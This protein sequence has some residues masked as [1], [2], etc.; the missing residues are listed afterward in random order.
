MTIIRVKGFKIFTDRHGKTRCYY[1]ATG[2]KIDLDKAPIGSAG[3][4]AECAKITALAEALK[5]KQPR[6]GTLGGLI[7]AYFAEDHFKNLKDRTRRDYRKCAAFL[8]KILDTPVHAIDTPLIAAIHDKAAGKIGWRQAN[9]LR[10]FLSEVFRHCVPKGLISAN[11]AEAVIVKP[12]PR[13]LAYANRPW[14]DSE[15][16]TVLSLAPPHIRVALALMA[17]TGL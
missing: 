11:Y 17:N 9:M 3:F 16:A 1:S 13:D 4:F 6:A 12:R 15:R 14:T 10:T 5:A 2:H 7:A 8:D